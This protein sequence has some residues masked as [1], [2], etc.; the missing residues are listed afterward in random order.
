MP[1]STKEDLELIAALAADTSKFLD[2][3]V[4]KQVVGDGKFVASQHSAQKVIK[5][6]IKA[7][8]GGNNPPPQ[9]IQQSASPVISQ[10][11]QPAPVVF[12]TP[13]ALPVKN[14]NQLE[15]EFNDSATARNIN[16]KLNQIIGMLAQMQEQ[17]NKLSIEKPK[18][19][20]DK[21]G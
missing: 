11:P 3:T 7:V 4:N 20:F 13:Q 18:K 2:S 6:A 15:F 1:T 10:P 5:D 19:K 16:S 12:N 9:P 21:T 17:I 8:A 14:D